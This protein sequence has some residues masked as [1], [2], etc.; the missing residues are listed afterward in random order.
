MK[1]A[2]KISIS[3]A[4]LIELKKMTKNFTSKTIALKHRPGMGGLSAIIPI[5]TQDPGNPLIKLKFAGSL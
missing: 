5:I 3:A 2:D 4:N 1:K